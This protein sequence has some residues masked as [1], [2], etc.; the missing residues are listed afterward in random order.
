[1]FFIKTISYLTLLF[2]LASCRSDKR[3]QKEKKDS[4]QFFT[5]PVEDVIELN[6]NRLSSEP[7]DFLRKFSTS[8]IDWQPWSKDALNHAQRSQKIIFVLVCSSTNK[9]SY[10]F[11]TLLEQEFAEEINEKYLPILADIEIAP[12]LALQCNLLANESRES[13]AFP[14]LLWLSHEGNPIAWVPVNSSDHNRLLT[15][16][17]RIQKTVEVVKNKS[18][19]YIIENSRFDNDRRLNRIHND[20]EN[21]IPTKLTRGE[22]LLSAQSL[23]DLYD[24]TVRTFDKTGGIPPGSL[25]TTLSRISTYPSIPKRL[26]TST[27][28]AVSGALENLIRSAIRDPLDG[29]FF[30][31]RNSRSFSIP[32]FTKHLTT[33]A[34]ML[35]ALA[36]SP[37]STPALLKA[38]EQLLQTLQISSFSAVT[39]TENEIEESPYI[40]SRNAIAKEL[41]EEEAHVAFAAFNILNLGN[42]PLGEDSQRLFF[43]RNTLGLYKSGPELARATGFSQNKS[44]QLLKNAIRKLRERRREIITLADLEMVETTPFLATKARLLTALT[45]SFATKTVYQ[46]SR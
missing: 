39:S 13:I 35:S 10:K 9:N 34:D 45:R 27:Q 7:T 15:G 25:I 33:Q 3:E 24:P 23:T 37:S 36:S 46:K 32:A 18:P 21:T 20:L 17:R 41:S 4:T 43:R 44:E 14:F 28:S 30:L 40:W 22:L 31:R 19:R 2:F 29:Y 5:T 6:S 11:A 42:I 1:M 8:T 26:A 38:E 16:F 12:E